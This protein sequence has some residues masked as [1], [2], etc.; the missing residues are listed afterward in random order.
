M[1]LY[2]YNENKKTGDV[3]FIKSMIR[4]YHTPKNLRCTVPNVIVGQSWLS[5]NLGF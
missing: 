4:L 3:V 2:I 1:G 5:A